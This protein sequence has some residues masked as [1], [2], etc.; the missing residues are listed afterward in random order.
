MKPS[1]GSLDSTFSQLA[2]NVTSSSQASGSS[3]TQ[4]MRALPD[5]MITADMSAEMLLGAAA[6]DFQADRFHGDLEL[7]AIFGLGD[8]RRRGA[9]HFDVIFLQNA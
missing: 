2:V 3:V 7:G 9:D 1:F 4:A 8:G 5:L 6:A